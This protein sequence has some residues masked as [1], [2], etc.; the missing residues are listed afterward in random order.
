MKEDDAMIRLFSRKKLRKLKKNSN[1][2]QLME[3]K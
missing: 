1:F 3:E 2:P